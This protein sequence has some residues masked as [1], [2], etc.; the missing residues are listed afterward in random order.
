[1]KNKFEENMMKQQ[2]FWESLVGC[3]LQLPTWQFS[4]DSLCLRQKRSHQTFLL[5][6]DCVCLME[7]RESFGVGGKEEGFG[8]VGSET[9]AKGNRIT[10][11]MG[12]VELQFK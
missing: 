6:C 11:D 3:I 4:V 1:M 10:G 8:L 12:V 9:S 2:A 7:K 5:L